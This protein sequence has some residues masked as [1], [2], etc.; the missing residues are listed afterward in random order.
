[1]ASGTN[2]HNA[3]FQQDSS[4]F[5]F[6]WE[7]TQR[8]KARPLLLRAESMLRLCDWVYLDMSGH[9]SVFFS[10]GQSVIF[11]R[12]QWFFF[13]AQF[14][15]Y[16]NMS[17]SEWFFF[18]KQNSLFSPKSIVLTPKAQFSFSKEWIKS[19]CIDHSHSLSVSLLISSCYFILFYFCLF[20]HSH[21]DVY[22][23]NSGSLLFTFYSPVPALQSGVF[24]QGSVLIR[25]ADQER[26]L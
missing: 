19:R 24:V 22:S 17:T 25:G 16:G 3:L 21:M 15:L 20:R 14:L 6:F 5:T 1:M 2:T 4:R 9:Q 18:L 26:W 12:C 11:F 13:H 8:N 10:Y 23:H 7:C